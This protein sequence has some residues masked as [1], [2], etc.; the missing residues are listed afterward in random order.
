[1]T[2]NEL[3]KLSNKH[4]LKKKPIFGYLAISYLLFQPMTCNLQREIKS[5]EKAGG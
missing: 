1:L 2:L 4:L 3:Q 5:K